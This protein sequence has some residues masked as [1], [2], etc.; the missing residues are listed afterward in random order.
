MPEISKTMSTVFLL[1][2]TVSN[3]GNGSHIYFFWQKSSVELIMIGSWQALRGSPSTIFQLYRHSLL[4]T[5]ARTQDLDLVQ[6][7]TYGE[8][9]K[10][11][12]TAEVTE[13]P[14]AA[15]AWES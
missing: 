9:R 15:A 5:F 12:R 2:L 4:C 6:I 10:C 14:L 13:P 8:E 7:G 3:Y 11:Q 1:L